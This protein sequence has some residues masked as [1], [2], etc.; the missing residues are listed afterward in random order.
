MFCSHILDLAALE[1]RNPKSQLQN[2]SPWHGQSA[3]P[4]VYGESTCP[5]REALS[6]SAEFC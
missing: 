4:C 6:N 2:V 3:E 5:L 1:S